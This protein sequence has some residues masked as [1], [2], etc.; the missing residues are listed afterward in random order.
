M[1]RILV[2]FAILLNV[3]STFGQ[4]TEEIEQT[5]GNLFGGSFIGAFYNFVFRK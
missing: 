5:K 1:K 3:I 4:V 2:I